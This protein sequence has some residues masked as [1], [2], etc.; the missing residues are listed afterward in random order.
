MSDPRDRYE[1]NRR[2]NRILVRH[3]VDLQ[4]LSHSC[5]ETTAYLYGTL[6]KE[7]GHDFDKEEVESLIGELHAL[8]H[9]RH[10]HYELVNWSIVPEM[11]CWSISPIIRREIR[12]KPE[13]DLEI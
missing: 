8:P 10:F 12:I 11:G 4:L 1:N 2:V 6:K 13:A 7:M 3:G 5:S 9:L